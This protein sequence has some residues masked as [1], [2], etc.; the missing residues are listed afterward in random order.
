M[1]GE[2]QQINPQ[3]NPVDRF[4]MGFY[5]KKIQL[6]TIVPCFPARIDGV[7]CGLRPSLFVKMTFSGKF[8]LS[9]TFGGAFRLSPE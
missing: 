1:Q 7:D 4:M 5:P 8:W 6:S 3:K 2:K 9:R